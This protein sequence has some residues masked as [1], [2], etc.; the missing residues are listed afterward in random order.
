M[1]EDAPRR[2]PSDL[3]AAQALGTLNDWMHG[4]GIEEISISRGDHT[5]TLSILLW[6]GFVPSH[7]S[8]TME[9][10]MR[11]RLSSCRNTCESSS[12]S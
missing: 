3:E 4:A 11:R 12:Q 9:C 1:S 5:P 6:D 2:F 7:D 8:Q 10:Y